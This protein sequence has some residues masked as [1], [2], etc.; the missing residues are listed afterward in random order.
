MQKKQN[1]TEK[2]ATT[3]CFKETK[4]SLQMLTT[5]N[6]IHTNQAVTELL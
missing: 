4:L 3:K 6:P 5:D 1:E 2:Y